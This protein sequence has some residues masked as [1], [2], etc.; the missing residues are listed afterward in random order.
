MVIWFGLLVG[1]TALGIVPRRHV[2]V[3]AGSGIAYAPMA[4]VLEGA[5]VDNAVP[6]VATILP[7]GLVGAINRK[8]PWTVPGALTAVLTGLTAV[9]IALLSFAVVH[10]TIA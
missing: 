6:F 1:V 10:L 3:L 9:T 2:T 7:I 5:S 8:H 4:L